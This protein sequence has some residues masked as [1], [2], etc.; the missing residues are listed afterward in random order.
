MLG[1]FPSRKF[2]LPDSGTLVRWNLGGNGVR[3]GIDGTCLFPYGVLLSAS[4]GAELGMGVGG[5]CSS[6]AAPLH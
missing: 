3:H 1:H 4:L 6:S 5:F 2:Q